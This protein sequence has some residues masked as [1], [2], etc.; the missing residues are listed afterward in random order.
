M[1]EILA[2]IGL[3]KTIGKIVEEKGYKSG[4]YKLLTVLMWFGGEI[5]GAIIGTVA[6]EEVESAQCLIYLFAL[7]GAG[8]GA[9]GAYSIANS[10]TA[11]GPSRE[12]TGTASM[13]R[14]PIPAII[15]FW[16]IASVVAN[17]SW[18][19]V[20]SFTGSSVVSGITAGLIAGLLQWFILLTVI[21]NANRGFL[22]IWIPV[23]AAGWTIAAILYSVL[24]LEATTVVYFLIAIVN[25]LLLGVLQWLILQRF[26]KAAIWWIPASLA[27]AV[28]AWSFGQLAFSLLSS[29]TLFNILFGVLGSI[30]TAI[31]L[32]LIF[33]RT[34][35]DVKA[36]SNQPMAL[37]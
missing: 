32:V 2:L 35:S 7:A 10:L 29:L 22:A 12:V 6:A 19:A 30:F 33:R 25:G 16:L 18:S 17:L 24:P 20:F 9:F 28:L 31:T 21:P 26:S 8:L 14:L 37:P 4:R 1:L 34:L 3:T 13:P 15:L 11:I 36:V 23:T 5:L 27:D